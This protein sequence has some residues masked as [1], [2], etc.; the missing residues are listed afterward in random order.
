MT[1]SHKAICSRC[2]WSGEVQAT[3]DERCWCPKCGHVV[4]YIVSKLV[5]IRWKACKECGDWMLVG[6]GGHQINRE[7]CKNTCTQRDHRR[8]VKECKALKAA[9][10]TISELA[11][12]FQTKTSTV[13]NWLTKVK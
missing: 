11:A 3:A 10:K 4:G 7:F 12:H 13:R 1:T 8:K 5:P 2:G 9:G 6:N